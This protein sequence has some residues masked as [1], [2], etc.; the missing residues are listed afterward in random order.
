MKLF[1]EFKEFAVKGNMMDMAIGII[2]GAAFN[3]V[4]DVLVKSVLLPPLS[5]LTDGVHFGDKRI[6][7]R[8]ALISADDTILK[9]EVAIGYGAFA[10]AFLDFLIVG[11]AVFLAV[12][13]MNR[14]RNKSQDTKDKT[15]STPK[16]IELLSKLTDLMEEQNTLLKSKR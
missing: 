12:K 9:N 5:L 2:I 10:E 1:R 8:D 11:F 3:R 6:I 4:I 7:L 15:I 14:L 16:D 13:F